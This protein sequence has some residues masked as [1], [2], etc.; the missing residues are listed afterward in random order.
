MQTKFR[1]NRS[2]T[3]ILD[4][5]QKYQIK[6][7]L[8]DPAMKNMNPDY[9][10]REFRVMRF[11]LIGNQSD[12]NGEHVYDLHLHLVVS[13]KRNIV[14]IRPIVKDKKQVISY[15]EAGLDEL[16]VNKHIYTIFNAMVNGDPDR[17]EKMFNKNAVKVHHQGNQSKDKPNSYAYEMTKEGEDFVRK[18]FYKFMLRAKE[19][20]PKTKNLFNV[21]SVLRLE[22]EISMEKINI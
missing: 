16:E 2:F 21:G 15:E 6:A 4:D 14:G 13:K 19:D 12:N 8:F 11:P 22:Q 20:N 3:S 10:V 1:V 18:A 17:V 7:L 5:I 9:I